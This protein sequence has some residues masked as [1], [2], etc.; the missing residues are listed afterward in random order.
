VREPTRLDPIDN[1]RCD[2]CGNYEREL[3][4]IETEAT[5][6]RMAYIG[7]CAWCSYC[8]PHRVHWY[9]EWLKWRIR[10]VQR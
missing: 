9:T 2:G 3:T 8:E 6:R 4:W 5:Y 10:K 7:R 1:G